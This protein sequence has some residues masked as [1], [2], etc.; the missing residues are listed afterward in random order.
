MGGS[1]NGKKS[2]KTLRRWQ[3]AQARRNPSSR[4]WW[5]AQRRIDRAHRRAKGLRDNAHH[6]VSS[7]LVQKYHTLGIET[8]NVAGMLKA[9]L[10]AKALADAGI[11]TLL[12]QVRYKAQWQGT[13]VIEAPQ[14]YPSSRTCSA[15]D[16]VNTELG[17]EPLWSCPG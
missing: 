3:Q 16:A 8:L 14:Q 6:H 11:S 12:R 9:G 1:P 17:R 5:K 4:G 2:L 7:A 10:Q 13:R 15:C